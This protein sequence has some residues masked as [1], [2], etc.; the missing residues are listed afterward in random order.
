MNKFFFTLIFFPVLFFSQKIEL[1]SIRNVYC[2]RDCNEY[3]NEQKWVDEHNPPKGPQNK[4]ITK[5][6]KIFSIPLEKRLKL[7]PFNEYD[8]IYIVNPIYVENI[9]EP[10]NYDDEKY[11]NTTRIIS[12]RE[13][14]K[15]S[16]ILFNYY[17]NSS[18]VATNIHEDIGCNCIQCEYPK[19][20]LLFKRNGKFEKYVAFPDNGLSRYNFS[21]NE[22]SNLDLSI[23]KEN[24]ILKIFKRDILPDQKCKNNLYVPSPL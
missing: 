5:L 13:K 24:E 12:A 10:R 15:L 16:D 6:K 23:E 7:Y 18:G 20:I 1:K 17:L 21:D 3:K 2:S 19:L 9:D 14:D 8:S 22:L 11:H 4:K